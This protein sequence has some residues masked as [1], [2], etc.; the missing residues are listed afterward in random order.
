MNWDAIG[1][2]GEIIGAIAVVGSLAYLATQIRTSNLA[3]KQSAAQELMNEMREFYAQI[4]SDNSLATL[5][6]KGVSSPEELSS[7]EAIQFGL[8]ITQAV[9]VWERIYELEEKEG[10][11]PWFSNH[12]NWSRDNLLGSKGF[13]YWY[14]HRQEQVSTKMRKV[15][16]EGMAKGTIYKGLEEPFL[17]PI[18]K[19][20]AHDT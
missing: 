5:W 12:V 10:I 7:S 8:L 16:D 13:Q 15:I 18:D 4:S 17:Q 2:V 1:A 9:L 3:V 14:E 6:T 20:S 19:E 11:E